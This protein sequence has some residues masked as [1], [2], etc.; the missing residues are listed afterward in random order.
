[1]LGVQGQLCLRVE[2]Q[3]NLD[4]I[5]RPLTNKHANERTKQWVWASVSGPVLAGQ[6]LYHMNCLPSLYFILSGHVNVFC[7]I[8]SYLLAVC[9]SRAMAGWVS[10]GFMCSLGWH[11]VQAT[12]NLTPLS[13]SPVPGN[14]ETIPGIPSLR[15]YL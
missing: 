7:P 5:V 8:A 6:T 9:I 3:T 15:W 12:L 2:F 4:Y 11:L 14:H 13:Q 10:R 1:M